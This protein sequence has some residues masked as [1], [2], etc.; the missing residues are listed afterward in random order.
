MLARL[1]A[2]GVKNPVAVHLLTLV[3]VLSGLVLYQASPREIFP[4]FTLERVRVTALYPGASPEDVEELVAVKLEDA[5]DGVDGIHE[6]ESTSQ[7]GVC[8]VTA[9]LTAGADMLRVLQDVDRAVAAIPDLPAEVDDPIVEEVKT[10]FPV[11]TLTI[12]GEVDETALKD[13]VRPIQRRVEA[14]PGIASAQPTGMRELQWHVELDPD[15]AERFGVTP[16]DV[17]QALAAR[18]LNVPGGVLERARD[19]VLVR[20]RGDTRTAREIEEAVVRARPDGAALRV[21]DVA[22]VR[23]GFERALTL[24]RYDGRP[25]LNITALKAKDGDIVEISRA[26]REIAR[27]LELPPG[28]HAAVHTDLSV[29]LQNRLQTMQESALQGFVLVLLSLYLLLNLRMALLVALGIPLAF[30]FTFA[31]MW[32]LGISVN[33]MSLFALILV[34]GMLVDDAII[35]SENIF[36][37]IELGEPPALAAVRGTAEVALP[38]L[39]TICTTVAAFLPMLLTPGEMG[40]WMRQVPIVVTLCLLGSLLECFA[41]LP[42]HVAELAQPVVASGGAGGHGQGSAAWFQRLL[43]WHERAI[44]WA[45]GVRYRLVAGAVGGSVVLVTVASLT[46]SFVLFGKFES[47]T[48]FLNFELPSTASLEETSERARVLEA[49]VLALPP[50]ER[51]ACITNIGISALDVNR[52]DRG[53]YLGQVVFDLQPPERRRRSADEILAGLRAQTDRLPGFTKLEYKGLQAGPGGAAIEVALGGDDPRALRAAADEVIGWLRTQTGV[54]DVFD[55]SVPGKAELEVGLD[56]E[57]AHALGLST[58]LVGAQVRDA[59]RGREATKVR[60]R[61]E[62]VELVVRYT[63]EARAA[64]ATLEDLWLATPAGER[65]PLAAVATPR[66]GRGLAKITRVDRRRAVTV[67]GDVDVRQANAIE[68]TDRLIEQFQGPLAARGVALEVK[69]Q[70][71]EAEQSMR[72]LL[73]AL[74]LSLLLI[75]LILGTQFKSFAQPLFVMTAIPFGIDGILIG[76]MLLGHDLSFLSMMGLVATSGIV[77]NDSLVLVDLVNRLRRQGVPTFEAAAQASVRRLRPILLTSLTTIFGLAPLAFFASGQAK[78]LSPMA[79]S[80]LFGIAFSTGLTL[81]VIPCLYVILEDL[82]EVV[83]LGGP[84]GGAHAAEH[85]AALDAALGVAPPG[86]GPGSSPD[87]GLDPE[88]LEAPAG[89]PDPYAERAEDDGQGR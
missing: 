9:R 67:F 80:I 46:T 82:K 62:D 6:L 88:T 12:Y 26:V 56:L 64:R 2:L 54:Q 19:E 47:D 39:A 61:D 33:M 24:G 23:P 73:Q 75:Y 57:A 87:D 34:L 48:Y 38:V 13:L 40:Q 37:R 3:L 66:E 43:A 84:Q 10:R 71:R 11:I 42:L 51:R 32:T 4:D 89:P 70:R 16:A 78:F 63:A 45:L 72:G 59:F 21:G 31:G 69:G 60:R 7:E 74:V 52:A 30:L 50:D 25:A 22:R 41:I 53:S 76:H 86:A 14:I 77:V 17:A 8:F 68:V 27:D 65:V 20:T 49:L 5:L 55:D 79:V 28:V 58:A 36:R 44:R 18:N 35:V 83:G 85:A 15:A 29:F 81:F 1:L